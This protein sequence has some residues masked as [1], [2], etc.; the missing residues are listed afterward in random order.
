M[1]SLRGSCNFW[2]MSIQNDGVLI[3]DKKS[4]CNC[5]VDYTFNITIIMDIGRPSTLYLAPEMSIQTSC[6]SEGNLLR[7]R[8][9]V[10]FYFIYPGVMMP[11]NTNGTRVE[12]LL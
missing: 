2:K 5:E 1:Q 12:S 6:T 4:P 11:P 7:T 8:V 10:C 3:L 9:Q